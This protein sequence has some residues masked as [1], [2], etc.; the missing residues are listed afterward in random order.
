MMSMFMKEHGPLPPI[1][2]PDFPGQEVAMHRVFGPFCPSFRGQTAGG[3]PSPLQLIKPLLPG[4]SLLGL[5][6]SLVKL[7]QPFQ[8]Q[9]EPR[10]FPGRRQ[11]LVLLDAFVRVS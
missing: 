3:R 9:L 11:G 10:S 6:E 7:D 5:A 2:C 4:R 1:V 8:R